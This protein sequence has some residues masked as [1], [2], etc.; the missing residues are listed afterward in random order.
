VSLSL[1]KLYFSQK[2]PIDLQQGWEFFSTPANLEKITPPSLALK[3]KHHH[4]QKIIYP[5]QIIV[6]SV[7]PLWKIS[8]EWITE[9]VAVQKPVYFIDEQKFGPYT[10][11]HHEHWFTSIPNGILIEDVI[12]YKVPFGMI[13]KALHHFK[14]RKDLFNIFSYRNQILEKLFGSYPS[15]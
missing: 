15:S 4:D 10:F 6:Y 12:Y 14:I 13:G 5:G 8:M 11:W 9:I 7:E 3:I 1:H 2:L